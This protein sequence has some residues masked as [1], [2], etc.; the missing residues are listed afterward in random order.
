MRKQILF[1]VVAAMIAVS[2][3][4]QSG[5]TYDGVSTTSTPYNAVLGS[6]SAWAN[7]SLFGTAKFGTDFTTMPAPQY[8]GVMIG[9]YG[10][11]AI[12]ELQFLSA[13]SASGYGFRLHGY[14][15]DG[16]FRIDRR[17]NSTTWSDFLTITP[18]GGLGIGTMSP[19]T[20]VHLYQSGTSVE[21][22][23]LDNPAGGTETANKLTFHQGLNEDAYIDSH[24]DTTNGWA[25]R[26]GT[27]N[28]GNNAAD[29]MIL[30]N[31]GNLGL[32]TMA[33]GNRL[34]VY[35]TSTA[36]GIA[37]D[38]TLAPAIN[39]RNAGTPKAYIGLATGAGHFF[40]DAASGDITIRSES[41][42]VLLGRGGVGGTTATMAIVGSN[43]GVGTTA[44][45]EKLTVSGNI[46]ATG[47]IS[48][49]GTIYA[50]YQDVAEWVSASG[51]IESAMVV[52]LDPSHDNQVIPSTR[53]Y[54]TSVAGVVSENPGMLLGAAA[55]NKEK[56]A[57]T[58]RVKVRVDATRAPIRIGDLLVTSDIAGMAMKSEPVDV[59]GVK[60]HRPGTV[61]G[62]ALQSLP[63]GRGEILV[64]L[65]LQ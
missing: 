48:A 19:Q 30:S 21:L 16:S 4:G 20:L 29:R 36:D 9:Q 65:S 47:N 54:D 28:A 8:G 15:G 1:V 53:A 24:Y 43:V 39:L 25:L 62:K 49:N 26:F 22:L 51:A 32:N 3:F 64:L 57:T 44:P 31:G 58:G 40:N 35:T 37:V 46:L 6:S 56:I 55:A 10:G 38:G 41:N 11:G 52:V 34:H 33:P 23:R 59:A 60:M 7:L 13:A 42:N 61:I 63:E 12:G 14:A 50:K 17:A 2:S 27:R 5:W 18:G 45:A